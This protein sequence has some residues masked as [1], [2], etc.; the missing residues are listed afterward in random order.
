MVNTEKHQD[1]F[2]NT[3]TK[4]KLSIATTVSKFKNPGHVKDKAQLT[5]DCISFLTILKARYSVFLFRAFFNRN[6]VF[7]W[8]PPPQLTSVP[9]LPPPSTLLGKTN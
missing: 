9:F 6:L 8:P 2:T 7:Q 4:T 5:A 3:G 1:Q